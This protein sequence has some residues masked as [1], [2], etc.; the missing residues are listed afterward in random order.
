[1]EGIFGPL[2]WLHIEL[3][4][5]FLRF[6]VAFEIFEGEVSVGPL[7]V[8]GLHEFV[9]E[10]AESQVF[11]VVVGEGTISQAID[12]TADLYVLFVDATWMV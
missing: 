5:F 11:G 10:V 2:T 8:M 1:M 12:S 6:V 7:A 4:D 9:V 3:F